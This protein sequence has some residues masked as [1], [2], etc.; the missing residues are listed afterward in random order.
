VTTFK[1]AIIDALEKKYEAQR[2][3]AEAN[4]KVYM[5]KPVGVGDHVNI[6]ETIDKEMQKISK[7]N[8]M[9]EELA[10]WR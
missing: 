6:V 3:E 7:A 10:N 1:Q 2:S 9:L 5:E 8:E 4:I